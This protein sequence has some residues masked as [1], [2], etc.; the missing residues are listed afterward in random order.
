M[1]DDSSSSLVRF[2]LVN[3][4]LKIIEVFVEEFRTVEVR[5]GS[6]HLNVASLLDSVGGS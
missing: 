4:V 5:V 3:V 2:L 6:A 1:H